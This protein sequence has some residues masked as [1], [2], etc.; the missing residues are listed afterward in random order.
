MREAR[1]LQRMRRS[2]TPS[3]SDDS[4]QSIP[5]PCPSV[6]DKTLQNRVILDLACKTMAL[7]HKNRV[8]QQ[9]VIALRK[10]T[11]EFITTIMKH[12]ENR[13]RYN[14]HVRLYGIPQRLLVQAESKQNPPLKIEPDA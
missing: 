9:K 10:E 5:S 3:S 13:R 1:R 6:V 11:T 8:I 2:N 4:I 7:M 12:P 14:E